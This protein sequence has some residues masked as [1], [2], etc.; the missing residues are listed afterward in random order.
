VLFS[1]IIPTY[2]RAHF[3][4]ETLKSV[5]AQTFTDYEIV[6][7]DDGSTDRTEEVL[8]GFKELTLLRQQHKGPG[9]ARNLGAARAHGQYLAFLDSDDLWFPWTLS[10]F[11]KLIRQYDSPA[12]L[13]AKQ[14]LFTDPAELTSLRELAL[15]AEVFE[16]YFASHRTPYWVGAGMSVLRREEFAK[17]NGYAKSIVNSEDHDLVLRMGEASGFVQVV[18]PV[19]LAYRRHPGSVT[20][21]LSRSFEGNLYLVAQERRGAYPGGTARARARREI[22]V[23]RTRPVILELMRNRMWREAWAIYLA[24]FKW[25]ASLGRYKFLIGAPLSPILTRLQTR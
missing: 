16:D 14:V 9:A 8:R 4:V 5:F 15:N 20:N 17:T 13:S 12:I 23:K 2:N 19:T 25:N 6:V 3:L 22:L 24:T 21:N 1:V 18:E 7:V 10:T 11:A